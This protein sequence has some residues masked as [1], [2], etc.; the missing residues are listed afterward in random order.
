[1]R[2]LL[3]IACLLTLVL[4]GCTDEATEPEQTDVHD[5]GDHEHDHNNTAPVA[6]LTADVHNGTAPLLVNFTLDGFDADG[7]NLTWVFEAHVNGTQI[8]NAT[9]NQ[10]AFPATINATFEGNGTA[11]LTVRDGTNST[12]VSLNIT[13]LAPPA[14][15]EE[16][17]DPNAPVD[18]GW[19]I[20]DPVTSLCHV[21][22][23]DAYGDTF[24]VSALGGGAW[25]LAEANGVDGL[26]IADDHPTSGT[27]AGFEVAGTEGCV[28]GDLIVI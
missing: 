15:A 25:V 1:M 3:S 6:N 22:E 23:Y 8:A 18:M 24:Y 20:F 11:T 26:Q 4:A 9:G 27:G 28:D 19:F 13:A 5:H 14:P 16:A 10:S 12:V 7:D 17:V 2:T 21:K